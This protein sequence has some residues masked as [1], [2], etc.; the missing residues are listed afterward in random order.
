MQHMQRFGLALWVL[1]SYV[2]GGGYTK[3]FDDFESILNLI[4]SNE[5]L[6]NH[7]MLNML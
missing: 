6:K 5:Q 1:A 7:L 4:F 2:N 3:A